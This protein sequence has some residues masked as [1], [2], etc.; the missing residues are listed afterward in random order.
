MAVW[1]ELDDPT[2]FVVNEAAEMVLDLHTSTF[3]SFDDVR[4]LMGRPPRGRVRDLQI[5][6][7]ELVLPKLPTP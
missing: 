3:Y 6:M 5:L 7:R 2:R 4:F 1:E